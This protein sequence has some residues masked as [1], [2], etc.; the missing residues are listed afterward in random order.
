MSAPSPSAHLPKGECKRSSSY[1][2]AVTGF[3]PARKVYYSAHHIKDL[4]TKSL[5]VIVWQQLLFVLLDNRLDILQPYSVSF[6]KTDINIPPFAI[7]TL[8][9][10][11]SALYFNLVKHFTF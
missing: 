4:V 3:I 9:L 7:K 6:G 1:L 10:L 2:R 8:T 5:E 11:D